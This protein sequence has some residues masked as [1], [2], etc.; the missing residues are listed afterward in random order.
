MRNHLKIIA[1]QH[2]KA[3]EVLEAVQNLCNA[4]ALPSKSLSLSCYYQHFNNL[5]EQS[6]PPTIKLWIRPTLMVESNKW[7][8]LLYLWNY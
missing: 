1:N 6:L 3:Y 7:R 5:R 2:L 4:P 8:K